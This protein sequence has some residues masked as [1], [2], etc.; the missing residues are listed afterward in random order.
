MRIS[1]RTLLLSALTLAASPAA[2]V[3][4]TA[5]TYRLAP[6]ERAC[7][8][9][10]VETEGSKIAFYFAVGLDSYSCDDFFFGRWG[11]GLG[12][13]ICDSMLGIGIC[14]SMLSP[15]LLYRFANPPTLAH[16]HRSNPAAPSTSITAS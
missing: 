11:L 8:Y 2:L 16:P 13:G 3:A 6:S 12:I 15:P 14:V 10:N 5:L 1:T 7:F 9:T 4:A